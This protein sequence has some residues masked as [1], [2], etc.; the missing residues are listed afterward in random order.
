MQRCEQQH[1]ALVDDPWGV[2]GDLAALVRERRIAFT[3]LNKHRNDE[4]ATAELIQSV[5]DSDEVI[6]SNLASMIDVPQLQKVLKQ[7][8]MALDALDA[9]LRRLTECWARWFETLEGGMP[10]HLDSACAMFDLTQPDQRDLLEI[11]FACS[12][13]GPSATPCMRPTSERSRSR[14][15]RCSQTAVPTAA[16]ATSKAIQKAKKNFQ[17]RRPG[18]IRKPADNRGRAPSRSRNDHPDAGPA[19]DGCW[20]GAR[21]CCDQN[22]P[23]AGPGLVRT[24][25]P[26]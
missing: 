25:R 16:P 19:C 15:S 2:L 22:G 7:P 21:R 3:K 10:S 26:C 23:A 14:A 9:D 8:A 5:A 24:A 12:C 6:R 11:H 20:T 1:F 18:L 17:K 4:W 13:L